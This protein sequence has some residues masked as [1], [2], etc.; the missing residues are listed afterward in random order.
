[1][2]PTDEKTL[3]VTFA[4]ESIIVFRLNARAMVFMA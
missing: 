2:V 4:A 3:C 1:M